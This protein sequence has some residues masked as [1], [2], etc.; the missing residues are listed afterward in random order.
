MPDIIKT[1]LLKTNG[2]NYKCVVHHISMSIFFFL[3]I[4]CFII[5][6]YFFLNIDSPYYKHHSKYLDISQEKII[7][8]NIIMMNYVYQKGV[9]DITICK[10][11]KQLFKRI[12]GYE[13]TKRKKIIFGQS[14][15]RGFKKRWEISKQVCFNFLCFIFF[16][17][18]FHY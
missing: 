3:F 12:N 13:S 16:F 14:W 1:S 6:I 7:Y 8:K 5:N 4:F 11:G 15:L 18:M 10:W 2:I 9:P 17:F